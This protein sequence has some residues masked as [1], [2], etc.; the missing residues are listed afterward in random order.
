[1]TKKRIKLAI[2]GTTTWIYRVK[3]ETFVNHKRD[4]K[5]GD[6]VEIC[7][8]YTEICPRYIGDLP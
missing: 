7:L 6:T 2:E 5:E 4:Q 8:K 1:M 3:K